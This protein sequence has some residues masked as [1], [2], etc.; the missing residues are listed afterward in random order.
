MDLKPRLA[1]TIGDPAGVGPE[2]VLKALSDPAVDGSADYLV[3][4]HKSVLD[5]AAGTTGVPNAIPVVSSAAEFRGGCAILEVGEIPP[6]GIPTGQVS[7]E[8]GKLSVGYVLEAIR[9]AKTGTVEAIVT[10]PINKAA[11]HK[12]GY[13]FPGHTEILARETDTPKFVMM[14]V[15][16][17]LRVAFVTIHVPLRKIFELITRETVLDTIR[18]THRALERDFG[19][20]QP[21]LGVCGLNPH[22][23]DGGRFGDEEDQV[24]IPAI[25]EARREG[26]QCTGP[27][28]PDTAFYT[29][30]KGVFDAVICQYHDQGHIP[31][32]LLAFETGVNV[33]LGL[34]I[35]RTSVDHGTAFDIAGQNQASPASMIE[36]IKLALSMVEARR[37]G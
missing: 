8:A 36:A 7:A 16:G 19:I 10:G 5:A 30:K 13:D 33:T 17:P 25:I 31:L 27:L 6:G 11:I 20:E 32:K 37:R 14:L 35:I 3:V 2:V 18:I 28:P 23:S 12:A 15:G 22:A 4:G 9:L 1:I 21:R 26:M 34:P 24:I 29:A